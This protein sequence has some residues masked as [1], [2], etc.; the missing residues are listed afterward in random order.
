MIRLL[1]LYPGENLK[2]MYLIEEEGGDGNIYVC[3]EDL[4]GGNFLLAIYSFDL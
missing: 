4:V 3:H 2:E 1:K